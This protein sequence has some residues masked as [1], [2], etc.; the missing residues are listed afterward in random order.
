M[1]IKSSQVPSLQIEQIVLTHVH[2]DHIRALES[3]TL[4]TGAR[5]YINRGDLP[6]L[7]R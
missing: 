6:L 7:D 4:D 3:V 5:V 2:H 1:V